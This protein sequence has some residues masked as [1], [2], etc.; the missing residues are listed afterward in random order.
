MSPER[1]TLSEGAVSD[2]VRLAGELHDEARRCASAGCWRAAL[3]LIGSALEAGI[4]ASACCLEPE[5]RARELWPSRDPSR[6]TLGQAVE[7]A[8]GA[9][10]LPCGR[11]GEGLTGRL[12]GEVGDA[13]V[14]LVV[15]RNMA[16][17]PVSVM[18]HEL[19]P[20]FADATHTRVTYEVCE[21]IMGAVFER[22]NAAI[23]AVPVGC[24]GSVQAR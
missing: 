7:L 23:R 21:G 3:V 5:L 4:V 10:W 17:H 14:F 2:L 11:P 15:V 20:D 22:L 9:G 24:K 8:I 1:F 6:W 19:A 18:R 13:I 12:D 16:T